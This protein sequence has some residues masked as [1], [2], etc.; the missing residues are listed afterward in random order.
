[1]PL[2]NERQAYWD[3]LEENIY[4]ENGE[5]CYLEDED[6]NDAFL[7]EGEYESDEEFEYYY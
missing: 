2:R 7:D 6:Y 3:D 1:M 5:D 4:D